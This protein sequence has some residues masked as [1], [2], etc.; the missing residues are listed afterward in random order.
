MKKENIICLRTA[1]MQ[2][3]W[4][5]GARITISR[6]KSNG[7]QRIPI[8]SYTCVVILDSRLLRV[9][10]AR[11]TRLSS[12]LRRHELALTLSFASVHCQKMSRHFILQKSRLVICRSFFFF[13]KIE[14]HSYSFFY[15]LARL[16]HTQRYKSCDV[17]FFFKYV[18]C[19]IKNSTTFILIHLFK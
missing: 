10:G 15:K 8:K 13:L 17:F 12:V 4:P 9:S 19:A 1:F 3:T 2:T 14:L 6:S 18:S 11:V 7:P 16:I 5:G